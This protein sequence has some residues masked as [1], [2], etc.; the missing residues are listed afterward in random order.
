MTFKESLKKLGIE[1]YEEKIFHSNSHGELFH[2]YDYCE[3]AEIL[4]KEFIDKDFFAP[5]FDE[6]VR[7]SKENWK[8][9]ESVYQHI[10]EIMK[11][12]L[13]FYT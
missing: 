9:P 1:K 3:M 12:S 6:I 5:W 2:L 11:Q 13:D 10:P 4:D 7:I 8:R